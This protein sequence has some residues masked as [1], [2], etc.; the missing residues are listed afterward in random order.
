[1][2]CD[3]SLN[4]FSSESNPK[5]KVSKPTYDNWVGLKSKIRCI[6]VD[7]MAN[8]TFLKASMSSQLTNARKSRAKIQ[9]ANKSFMDADLEG[10]MP[11]Y[12]INP[13][14]EHN[15]HPF[16][17]PFTITGMTVPDLNRELLSVDDL[18]ADGFSIDLRHPN[19]GEGPPDLYRPAMDGEEE[20][21]IPLSYDWSG[22]GGF[23]M[24]YIPS[25][26]ISEDDVALI[27]AH[28]I[29]SLPP[30][31]Q[32][33]R[34]HDAPE[35]HEATMSTELRAFD[36][37]RM[38]LESIDDAKDAMELCSLCACEG[39]TIVELIRSDEP[40]PFDEIKVKK[41]VFNKDGSL[42][43][44]H[45]V[46]S[47]QHPEERMIK[48][49]LSGLKRGR[50]LLSNEE[51]HRL[52]G[53]LGYCKGCKICAQVKGVM[54]RIKKKVNPHRETRPGFIFAM[55]LL[56]WSH[57]SEEGNR[58]L[59]VLRDFAVGYFKLIPLYAKSDA[60]DAFE[61][62]VMEIRNDPLFSDC[63][64]PIVCYCR[65]DNAGEWSLNYT[66]WQDMC[67]RMPGGE[68]KM[69][70]VSPDRHAQENGYAEVA[71][72]IV[73]VTVKSL[74]FSR[75][76]PESWWQRAAADAEFLLNRF[77]V[78]SAD[79]ALPI[80][81]DVAS[82]IE[83]FYRGQYSRRQV[84]RELSYYVPVGTPCIVHD[85]KV[86]GSALKPK[87]LYGIARG[88]YREQVFFICPFTGVARRSKSYTAMRLPEG[89]NY[90]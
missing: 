43:V 8:K 85:N 27:K 37:R 87:V 66:A 80:D 59:I 73:E 54:R 40:P 46:I 4:A 5:Y 28:I 41:C 58:Y 77:P 14:S 88:M 53:H 2:P 38:E 29:D 3:E 62:W 69:I 9:V 44:K 39:S 36:A 67:K 12:I 20:V 45:E 33:W 6:H 30:K 90:A 48:G 56:S 47:A 79:V 25:K 22:N 16:V 84:Y 72:S 86:K 60:I 78:T 55:D 26:H 51:A 81:G 11:C 64:Y 63:N 21:R 50:A 42:G 57:A 61:E 7:T 13:N 10:N 65:T 32:A 82:P 52:F 71:V 31:A 35:A 83:M 17:Q 18:Y 74:L 68:V 34:A 19:R 75:A 76:L 24:F 89:V 49:T 70:Y 15:S 1:M 23:R